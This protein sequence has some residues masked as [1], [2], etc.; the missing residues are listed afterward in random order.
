MTRT[1][2]VRSMGFLLLF[3]AIGWACAESPVLPEATEETAGAAESG[4][5]DA[6]GFDAFRLLLERNIFNAKRTSRPASE[7]KSAAPPSPKQRVRLMGVCLDANRRVAL[8]EESDD[9]SPIAIELG[10]FIAGHRIQEIR[11]DAVV[12]ASEAATVE[13][14]VGAG[15]SQDK[16]GHWAVVEASAIQRSGAV[17]PGAKPKSDPENA[18]AETPRGASEKAVSDPAEKLRE[19]RRRELGS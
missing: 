8:F 1:F 6:S 16:D 19:R 14:S 11:V 7:A 2:V 13:L 4:A 10:G 17:S 3:V 15:L 18:A 5:S 9:V 12:M